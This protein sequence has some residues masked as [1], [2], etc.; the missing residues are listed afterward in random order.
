MTDPLDPMA[1]YVVRPQM[2]PYVCPPRPG[3]EHAR[4][5]YADESGR[6]VAIDLPVKDLAH[7]VHSAA[8]ALAEAHALSPVGA[9]VG[10]T[11]PA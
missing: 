5:V 8:L 2:R 4:L 11:R 7:L 1:P 3:N 10:A 9:I 6:L